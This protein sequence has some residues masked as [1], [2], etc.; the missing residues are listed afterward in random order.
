M[1]Q[2]IESLFLDNFD[3][4]LYNLQLLCVFLYESLLTNFHLLLCDLLHG[5]YKKVL[6]KKV[7]TMALRKDEKRT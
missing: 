4:A 5:R 6:I 2:R 1:V 7:L 3:F